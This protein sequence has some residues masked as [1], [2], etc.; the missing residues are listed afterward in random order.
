M[1][2]E[3]LHTHTFTLIPVTHI[4][5]SCLYIITP[6]LTTLT[7]E[8]GKEVMEIREHNHALMPPSEYTRYELFP[9]TVYLHRS[10]TACLIFHRLWYL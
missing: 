3:K 7:A 4:S 8:D 6:F 2:A 5:R 9:S 1:L 10:I